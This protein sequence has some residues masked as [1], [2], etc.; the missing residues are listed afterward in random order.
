MKWFG[1]LFGL[2]VAIG[3]F[4]TAHV[5]VQTGSAAVPP[6]PTVSV[7]VPSVSVPTV[8]TPTVP[9]VPVP[10][11]PTPTVPVPSTPSPTV[12]APPAPTPPP[13]P[14]VR[15]PP[16][17]T[18]LPPT[19]AQSGSGSD[20]G[21]D[22]G[23]PRRAA[24]DHDQR[25]RGIAAAVAV[26]LERD[27]VTARTLVRSVVVRRHAQRPHCRNLAPRNDDSIAEEEH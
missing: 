25:Q 17:T 4:A 6:V 21:S 5:L 3:G 12:P 1:R 16:V 7:T 2:I 18:S 19:T 8:T 13:P 10:S 20:A 14:P 11:V 23:A 27:G 9:T 22:P 24:H 26:S 15:L